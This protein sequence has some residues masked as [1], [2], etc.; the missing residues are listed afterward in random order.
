MNRINNTF[1]QQKKNKRAAFITYLVCG[2]PDLT[3][4]LKLMHLM[5]DSGVDLIELGIP[6][7]DP[8]ADGPTIQKGVERALKKNVSLKD[9]LKVVE[10][11]RKKNQKT[12][13]VLMGYINPIESMG[14]D[15]FA[16]QAK[17]KGVDGVLLVD[18]PPEESKVINKILIK[19][20]LCQIYLASPTTE[21]KR[22]KIIIKHSSGYLYY[23][24][25]KGIT[26]SSIID[27]KPIK[28]A[29]DN[30]RKLSKN[31][32]PVTVG[33]GI[34]DGATAKNIGKFSDGIIIGSSI[35]ELIEKYMDNKAV[36]YKKIKSFLV[37]INKSIG[38][39]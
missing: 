3:S 31:N 37:S 10:S 9:V 20:N 6:F 16:I 32:I 29:V 30:I 8:I 18:S 27:F 38:E 19:N 7:T 13:I 4:T 12:P 34:K 15:K 26:G 25:V 39:K 5:V 11:F 1:L 28:K 2:D 21:K 24:S 33:F 35:V 22:L 36:M 23:V 14:Y 17:N